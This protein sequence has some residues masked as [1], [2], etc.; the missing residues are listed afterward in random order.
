MNLVTTYRAPSSPPNHGFAHLT[1]GQEAL[2]RELSGT[3]VVL[4]WVLKWE[5]LPGGE[6]GMLMP[7]QEPESYLYPLQNVDSSP[8]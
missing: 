8:I 7:R 6:P 5:V 3:Q 2:T 4:I 1:T